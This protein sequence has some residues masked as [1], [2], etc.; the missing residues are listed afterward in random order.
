MATIPRISREQAAQETARPSTLDVVSS[1][2]GASTSKAAAQ[3]TSA[4]TP[5]AGQTAADKQ[6]GYREQ[7]ASVPEFASFGQLV[8]SS[9]KTAMLTESETEYV[10]G[11]VK[12]FFKE[13]VVFQVCQA[14]RPRFEIRLLTQCSLMFRTLSLIRFWR[15][16]MC[17]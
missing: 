9:V 3:A 15:T 6:N 4:A 12:H 10:V 17:G 5:A 8:H 1:S 7:L 13:H 2:A 11:C 14:P 16:C